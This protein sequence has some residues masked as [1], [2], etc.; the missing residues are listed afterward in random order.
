[1]LLLENILLEICS[2]FIWYDEKILLNI[3]FT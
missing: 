2:I 1:M 3:W